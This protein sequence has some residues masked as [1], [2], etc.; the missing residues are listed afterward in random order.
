MSATS[1]TVPNLVQIRP[2]GTSG[3]IREIQPMFLFNLYPLFGNSPIGLTGRR[4][5][6]LD[7]SN[8]SDTHKDVPF[9]V[10]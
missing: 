5:F 7:G 3:Q 6:A 2:R 1:T 8:D 9:G 4:I 10:C